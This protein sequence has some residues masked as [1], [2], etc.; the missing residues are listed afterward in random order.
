M[1]LTVNIPS[2][3]GPLAWIWSD[4]NGPRPVVVL[5]FIAA[6]VVLALLSLVS[7]NGLAL[8]ILL[9][10]LLTFP[11]KSNSGYRVRFSSPFNVY[12]PIVQLFNGSS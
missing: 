3:A 9:C 2:L 1:F 8:T 4:K 11:S 7:H 10:V 12:L 5:G 6:A